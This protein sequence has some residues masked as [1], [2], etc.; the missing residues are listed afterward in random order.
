MNTHHITKGEVSLEIASSDRIAELHTV[1]LEK[2]MDRSKTM[3]K[4]KRNKSLKMINR[5]CKV[6]KHTCSVMFVI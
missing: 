3:I 6:M 5:E 2:V 4:F 1:R